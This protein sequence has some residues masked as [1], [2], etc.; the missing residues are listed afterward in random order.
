MA[1]GRQRRFCRTGYPKAFR[2][3]AALGFSFVAAAAVQPWPSALFQSYCS[4]LAR[5]GHG[6]GEIGE[7]LSVGAVFG[8]QK[9]MLVER[10]LRVEVDTTELEIRIKLLLGVPLLWV[11]TVNVVV[12]Q[13][14]GFAFLPRLQH[15]CDSVF[16]EMVQ[17]AV[18]HYVH[19]T[20]GR[21]PGPVVGEVLR[22]FLDE[23][24]D[25]IPF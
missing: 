20:V 3:V 7:S 8:G 11:E 25:I 13:G 16:R 24:N 17:Q 9:E 10:I 2:R 5:Q 18:A 22:M 15:S 23:G 4:F 21:H 6:K 1:G 19:Q 14:K 12:V